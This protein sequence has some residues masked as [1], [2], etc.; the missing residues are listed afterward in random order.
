VQPSLTS[1]QEKEPTE[2]EKLQVQA[3]LAAL[4]SF[5]QA[6]ATGLLTTEKVVRESAADLAGDDDKKDPVDDDRDAPSAVFGS[7]GRPAAVDANEQ[8]ASKPAGG[9]DEQKQENNVPPEGKGKE[10][11]DDDLEEDFTVDKDPA[12]VPSSVFGSWGRSVGKRKA[13][14]ANNPGGGD[15]VQEKTPP[16]DPPAGKGTSKLGNPKY[17]FSVPATNDYYYK[18]PKDASDEDRELAAMGSVALPL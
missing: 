18:L 7:W 10:T 15:I 14:A 3:N 2:A 8:K 12:D 1:Q 13:A 4:H 16:E 5:A 6:A 11:V 17:C 9:G